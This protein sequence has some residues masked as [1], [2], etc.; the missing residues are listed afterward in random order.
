MSRAPVEVGV[1][2]APPA[3]SSTQ[4]VWGFSAGGS[5]PHTKAAK[6]TTSLAILTRGVSVMGPAERHRVVPSAS[7]ADFYRMMRH[8]LQKAKRGCLQ[9]LTVPFGGEGSG[10]TRLDLM[11]VTAKALGLVRSDEVPVCLWG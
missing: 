5:V 1:C 2:R 11:P 9:P 10:S 3:G 6:S 7:R 4:G 8:R